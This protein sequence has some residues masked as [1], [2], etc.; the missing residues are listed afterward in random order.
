MAGSKLP[1]LTWFRAIEMLLRSP[2]IA[3]TEFM[4]GIPIQR[5]A[6]AR[7]VIRKILHERQAA[8]ASAR[9]A[10][11]ESVYARRNFSVGA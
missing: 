6:T 4:A 9:L 8:D 1:L 2:A 10:G 11:L 5:A 7:G 3:L